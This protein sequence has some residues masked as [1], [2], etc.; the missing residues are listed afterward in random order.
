MGA[1]TDAVKAEKKRCVTRRKALND[2]S[3]SRK[4]PP[5][6]ISIE[7]D[8]VAIAKAILPKTTETGK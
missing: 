7:K 8:P 2:I 5:N 3:N 4:L 6:F 1:K